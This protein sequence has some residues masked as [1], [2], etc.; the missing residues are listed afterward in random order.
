MGF[1]GWNL[2]LVAVVRSALPCF[3]KE[4]WGTHVLIIFCLTLNCTD[5][6]WARGFDPQ[7]VHSVHFVCDSWLRGAVRQFL[8]SEIEYNVA[9]RQHLLDKSSVAIRDDP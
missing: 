6:K 1:D 3:G 4:M 7:L 5:Y 8:E 9:V 2:E